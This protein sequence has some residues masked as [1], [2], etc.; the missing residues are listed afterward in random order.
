MRIRTSLRN[1]VAGW[2]GI[3]LFLAGQT[4][5]AGLLGMSAKP[6]V[7]KL[8]LSYNIKQLK[9]TWQA[10]RGATYYRLLVDSNGVSGFTPL[11]DQISADAKM[12]TLPIA[13]YQQDWI[14]ARYILEACN[15][16]GCAA[17]KQISAATGMLK[18][19]GYFK[20]S[21]T[22]YGDTYGMAV[23]VSADGK[24]L[25]VGAPWEGSN[26]TGINGNQAD[27]S[28]ASSGA[29]YVYSHASG[30][31]GQQAYLKASN[32]NAGDEFGFSLAISDDGNT[33]AV[34][35]RYEA[36]SGTAINANQTDNETPGAGAVYVFTR[37]ASDWNQQAYV[38]AS[39]AASE[40]GFGSAIALSGDGDTLAVGARAEDGPGS[41]I[42]SGQARDCIDPEP[43]HCVEGS[44]AVYV[45]RREAGLWA[46]Q[47]YIKASN[48]EAADEF[49][50]S[51]ALNGNGQVLAVGAV[52]EDSS[53][54]GING[55][56][57][58][59][60]ASRSGAVY[61]FQRGFFGWSQQAYVKAANTDMGLEDGDGF[62][63]SVALNAMGDVLAVGAP[64][65]SS[66]AFGVNGD[67]QDDCGT[68]GLNCMTYSGAVY[69]FIQPGGVWQQTTYLKASN[70][71]IEDHF[72]LRVAL[73]A[74]GGQL[75]VSA[76]D[77][78]GAAVGV[79]GNAMDN[80]HS[81]AG[82]AYMFTQSANRW[83]QT[84]YIKATNTQAG[85]FFGNSLALS[86]DGH[87]LAVGA[88]GEDSSATGINGT[89]TN[90]SAFYSGAV[91]LY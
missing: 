39:N 49:G 23:A 24:T 72:G 29:V 27:N 15:N 80:S 64:Y 42:N 28:A 66:G 11:A 16:Q 58:D 5:Q 10:S 86:R 9:F 74:A 18:T 70:P 55:N 44:G 13:V 84:A 68:N 63:Y 50:I 61:V 2:V 73:N 41:G 62:G 30:T 33:L 20:A 14:N 17:S 77:E 91:Y 22:G 43:A 79:G 71:G 36:G 56:Q 35:A 53:A 6:A 82:A 8:Q 31:W 1:A 87:A 57:A 38:K 48:A 69:L 81:D 25:A 75:A 34:G 65:E 67:S 4:A 19:I 12:Y 76:R 60:S 3:S 47:A 26:A 83:A 89:Q 45:Y 40:D 78:D 85:D 54:R 59:N 32:G 7:P 37:Q 88:W 52:G 90:N 51:L 46:H 21:N